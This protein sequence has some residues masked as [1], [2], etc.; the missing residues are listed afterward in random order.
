MTTAFL[1]SHRPIGRNYTPFK[2]KTQSTSKIRQWESRFCRR[3]MAFLIDDLFR[4]DVVSSAERTK[5]FFIRDILSTTTETDDLAVQNDG[6]TENADLLTRT[7]TISFPASGRSRVSSTV[8]RHQLHSASS[9][10]SSSLNHH[11]HHQ[12]QQQLPAS[13]SATIQQHPATFLLPAAEGR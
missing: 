5:S 1:M 13:L 6:T 9:Y 12:H 3:I 10:H 11:H 7:S 4:R 8:D 2:Y